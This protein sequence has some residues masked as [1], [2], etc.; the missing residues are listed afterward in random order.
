[1]YGREAQAVIK[2]FS[3]FLTHAC[4]EQKKS[5]KGTLAAAFRSWR[6]Y[7]ESERETTV[8]LKWQGTNYVGHGKGSL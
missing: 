5:G 2:I 6:R 4:G 3:K 1:M 8:P 7:D